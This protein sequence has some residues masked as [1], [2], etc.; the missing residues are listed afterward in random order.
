LVAAVSNA[1]ALGSLAAGYLFPEE[2]RSEIRKIRALTPHPFAVNLF[3]PSKH[4]VDLIKNEKMMAIF[5]KI[6]PYW[7]DI[8]DKTPSLHLMS[9]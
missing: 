6:C 3:I 4:K 5:E 1:G 2:M 7:H 9:K 8:E